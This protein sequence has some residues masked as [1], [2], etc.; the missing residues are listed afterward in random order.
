MSSHDFKDTANSQRRFVK[1]P[2]VLPAEIM[3]LSKLSGF[4]KLPLQIQD[5]GQQ[6]HR[7]LQSRHEPRARPSAAHPCGR[8]QRD[9]ARRPRVTTALLEGQVPRQDAGRGD[10]S[11]G[12]CARAAMAR[13]RGRGEPPGRPFR[14]QRLHEGTAPT[15]LPSPGRDRSGA[16][17]SGCHRSQVERHRA[18]HGGVVAVGA[19]QAGALCAPH[20][21]SRVSVRGRVP[22]HCTLCAATLGVGRSPPVQAA[23]P[24]ST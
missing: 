18:G 5:H 8:D 9:P 24:V 20:V 19:S 14:G 23:R 1:R 6:N 15:L 12:V 3:N 2:L 16:R 13:L 4:L 17:Q 22:I 7:S 11:G 21:A 10:L